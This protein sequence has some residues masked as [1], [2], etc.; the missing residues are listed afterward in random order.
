[1]KCRGSGQSEQGQKR[2]GYTRDGSPH[3][4]EALV[5]DLAALQTASA[6]VSDA[7]P[8]AVLTKNG[9]RAIAVIFEN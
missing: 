3:P 8:P 4:A 1:M 2:S 7:G 5:A 6:S 9:F